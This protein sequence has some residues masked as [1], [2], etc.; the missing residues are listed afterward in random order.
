MISV[1]E[2]SCPAVEARAITVYFTH[3]KARL[4]GDPILPFL[5]PNAKLPGLG[6]SLTIAHLL[7][8]STVPCKPSKAVVRSKVLP[9]TYKVPFPFPGE[10]SPITFKVHLS[11]RRSAEF[12][13]VIPSLA[14]QQPDQWD[15]IGT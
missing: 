13:K 9:P 14:Y 12:A 10:W 6:V 15:S 7:F 5:Q 11:G 3:A 4:F 2:S 1:R 8:G